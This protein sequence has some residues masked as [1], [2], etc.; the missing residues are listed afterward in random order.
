MFEVQET[1]SDEFTGA[2]IQR[3]IKKFYE[4]EGVYVENYFLN[5]VT[6]SIGEKKN[7]YFKEIFKQ[8]SYDL[9]N[10]EKVTIYLKGIYTSPLKQ[11]ERMRRLKEMFNSYMLDNFL[12]K[13]MEYLTVEHQQELRKVIKKIK[14]SLRFDEE[15]IYF[16][17]PSY[18]YS[19]DRVENYSIWH[20]LQ[21]LEFLRPVSHLWEGYSVEWEFDVLARRE[22]LIPSVH[23]REGTYAIIS[24]NPYEILTASETEYFNS[25]LKLDTQKDDH[26]YHPTLSVYCQAP[27]VAVVKIFRQ[28]NEGEDSLIG[29]TFIILPKEEGDFA[30]TTRYYGSNMAMN[31]YVPAILQKYFGYTDSFE[32]SKSVAFDNQD[33]NLYFDSSVKVWHRGNLDKKGLEEIIPSSKYLI[34]GYFGLTREGYDIDDEDITSGFYENEEFVKDSECCQ[35]CG[36]RHHIDD[37]YFIDDIE[38]YYCSSCRD[39]EA[40][41]CNYYNMWFSDSNQEFFSEYETSGYISEKAI[42]NGHYVLMENGDAIPM[43]DAFYCEDWDEWFH[44]DMIDGFYQH[45]DGGYY[46]YPE[47]YDEDEEK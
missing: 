21:K 11:K 43:E 16:S 36:A 28:N 15:V 39:D 5:R 12:K 18:P 6:A 25:C 17:H 27:N 14:L 45:M 35:Y 29:R 24:I 38:E 47:T 2:E 30:F 8:N 20:I 40:T 9:A 7:T 3:N 10:R 23:D 1:L 4:N 22:G 26:F 34:K 37:L 44:T 32:I 42:R 31:T 13:S 46:S 19:K 33:F 41:Y